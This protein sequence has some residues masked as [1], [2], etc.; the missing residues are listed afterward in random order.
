MCYCEPSSKYDTVYGTGCADGREDTVKCSEKA[1]IPHMYLGVLNGHKICGR[2]AGLSFKDVKR[3]MDDGTGSLFCPEGT[4]PC[5]TDAL[6]GATTE[7]VL[8]DP[9]HPANFVICSTKEEQCPITNISMAYD[10][11]KE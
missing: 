6:N 1:A 3:P 4:E 10:D 11:E 7:Q 9:N 8:A 2:H 5:D